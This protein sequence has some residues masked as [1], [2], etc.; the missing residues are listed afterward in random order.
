M[1]AT[2]TA[3]TVA[4]ARADA[5]PGAKRYEV[6][7]ARARGLVLRV[8][9]TGAQWQLRYAL[10]GRDVRLPLGGIDAWTIAEARDLVGRA[11]AMLRDRTGVPD[12]DWLDRQRRAAGK[13]EP[14]PVTVAKPK[15]LFAWTYAQGRTKWLDEIG[16]TRR[17]AT[18]AD[19]KSVLSMPDLAGLDKKPLPS[20][21]RGDLAGIISK[22][23]RSGR[24]STA[25]HL[26]RV[27]RPFWKWL[28]QD[29]Q[30]G[31]SGILPGAMDG[32]TAPERT[33]DESDAAGEYVPPL[34]E[35][36]RIVAICRSGAMDAVV[37]GAVELTVWTAQ[38]RRAVAE[39]TI[40]QF[41][42]IGGGRGLWHVP[43]ASR[44]TRSKAGTKKRP[45]VIPL[46]PAAWSC[47][48]RALATATTKKSDYLFPQLRAR[49]AGDAKTS[50]H[51]SSITH[52]L[53][54]MPGVAAS[55]HDL[56]RAFG[57]HGESRF[58][59]LRSD[60]QSILDHAAGSGDVTGT[61]YSL[62]DGTHR[63]WPIMQTWVAGLLPYVDAA[64][65]GLG[66]VEEIRA[67]IAAKRYG[68]QQR[69]AE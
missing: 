67:A 63:T 43:P 65:A 9:A 18:Y 12:Q 38:R 33:L 52:T 8:G 39:A 16:R 6:V 30:A 53:G 15:D 56:R 29:G 21:S 36:G 31:K 55:P 34:E 58:G 47:V 54:F 7:D 24:E 20:I 1:P 69:A 44:K 45:H 17:A 14:L 11:Q 50:I 57:T 51:P 5:K 64:I 22:I 32:L 19:Y 28:A 60:V 13:A 4:K 41:E 37:A 62:H 3:A 48:S 10:A 40:D 25:E 35:L 68:D 26:V 42:A 66:P 23:H 46:P 61:H 2:I 59:L 49:R 27:V